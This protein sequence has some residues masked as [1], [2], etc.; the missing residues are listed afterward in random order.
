MNGIKLDLGQD[1]GTVIK[2]ALS[3]IVNEDKKIF[4]DAIETLVQE[5]VQKLR[6]TKVVIPGRPIHILKQRAHKKFRITATLCN[7]S[8][9]CMLVGP[10]GTGKT[11]LA[12]QVAKAA[13]LNFAAISCSAGMSEA[14]LTGRMLF[15]GEYV[16]SQFV[17]IFE[18]GGVFL[19][20]EIDAADPNTLL[21]INSALANGYINLVNRKDKPVAKRHGDTVIIVAGNSYGT[22]SDIYHGRNYLDAAFLDRFALTKIEVGYDEELEK[23]FGADI[24]DKLVIGKFHQFRANVKNYEIKR[25]VS[26]RAIIDALMQKKAGLSMQGIY[27]RFFQGWTPEEIMKTKG[28]A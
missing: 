3:K 21:V 7:I 2:D 19:F 16:S 27:D 13:N 11:T 23:S 20:D 17:E 26:T 9:Q 12:A 25:T 18:N 5:E 28:D 15:N 1:I 14:H 4:T 8:R 10:A 6:P 22:G 24:S